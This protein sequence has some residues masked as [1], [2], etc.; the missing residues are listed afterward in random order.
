[1]VKVKPEFETI[2]LSKDE[3]IF[4]HRKMWS[5]MKK[6]LGD[7]P[8]GIARVEYK[9]RWCHQHKIALVNDCFLCHY[10]Y[11]CNLCPIVWPHNKC[12]SLDP[13]FESETYT[14]MPISDILNLPER[15]FTE[16]KHVLVS[17]GDIY[18]LRKML[19][20]MNKGE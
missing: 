12:F 15:K 17:V 8:S 1:M 2:E 19:W 9:E 3:I 11:K 14:S 5:D 6:E 20:E 7:I 18:G 13:V 4:L 16:E 10:T